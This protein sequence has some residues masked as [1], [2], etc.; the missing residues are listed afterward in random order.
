M[1]CEHGLGWAP[2]LLPTP[3]RLRVIWANYFTLRSLLFPH[4]KSSSFRMD[5]A[6]V[7]TK[8]SWFTG[9][10]SAESQARGRLGPHPLIQV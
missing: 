6:A 1:R 7:I 4:L 3:A 2:I 9:E 8:G 5:A 10:G